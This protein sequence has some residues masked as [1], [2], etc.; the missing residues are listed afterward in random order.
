MPCSEWGTCGRLLPSNTIVWMYLFLS[1]APLPGILTFFRSSIR[2]L[3]LILT[4]VL[5]A[6]VASAQEPQ[7]TLTSPNPQNNGYFGESAAGLSDVDGDGL[8]DLLIGAPREDGGADQSGRVYA[9]SGATGELIHSLVSPSPVTNG[10]FGNDVAAVGDLDGDGREEWLIGAPEDESNVGKT[11]AAY[12]FSGDGESLILT[13]F[14]P[15]PE[16]GGRFGASVAAVPDVDGDGFDDLLVGAP[17]EDADSTDAGRAYLFSGATGSLLQTVTSQN[18]W[19]GGSFGESVSGVEDVDGDGSGDLLVGAYAEEPEGEEEG[20]RAYLFSGATGALL[21]AFVSP[22]LR[23]RSNFGRSVSSV[24]DIDG[25]G[26][27]DV[28]IGS[29]GDEGVSSALDPDATGAGRAYVFSGATGDLIYTLV[30]PKDQ[31]LGAFGAAVAGVQDASG[32]GIDD[33]LVG[34]TF[35]YAVNNGKGNAYLYSGADGMLLRRLVSATPQTSSEFGYT[36]AGVPDVD[37]DGHTDLLV[38]GYDLNQQPRWAGFAYLFSGARPVVSDPYGVAVP[39]SLTLTSP[40]AQINGAFGT[41]ISGVPDADGDGHDDILVGASS[42]NGGEMRSGQVHLLSGGRGDVLLSIP[43]PDPAANGHFGRAVAGVPDLDG[44]GRGDLLVAFRHEPKGAVFIG[45]VY[46]LSGAS[47]DLLYTLET[48]NTQDDTNRNDDLDGFGRAMAGIPD[49]D[50]DGHGDFIIGA[51][52]EWVDETNRGRAY[53]F[54]GATGELIHTL[55]GPVDTGFTGFGQSVAGV[56]DVDGDGRWDVLVSGLEPEFNLRAVYVYSGA[57]G[58]L[59][60]RLVSPVTDPTGTFGYAIS[61]VPDADGDGRGDVLIGA[62]REHSGADRSGRAYLF[63]G[64]TG[65]LIRTIDHPDPSIDANFGIAVSGISDTDGDGLGDLLVSATYRTDETAFGRVY[66]ISASSGDVVA[67][68]ASPKPNGYG[69]FGDAIAGFDNA[70]GSGSAIVAAPREGG[71]TEDGRVYV[72]KESSSVGIASDLNA[73]SLSLHAYPNPTQG[74]IALQLGT[75]HA[76]PV[77]IQLFDVLG[78]CLQE[79][80]YDYL[81]AG[82]HRIRF[83]VS[84]PVSGMYLIRATGSAGAVSSG[85]TVVR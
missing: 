26:R 23:F 21:Q 18:P 46:A 60:H 27:G 56:P 22:G 50:G 69:S 57:T 4:L 14:S 44:D 58:D 5:S 68:F 47:G 78:R 64:A 61:G 29:R 32:D 8:G 41:S 76:G 36:L 1:E 12:L 67:T 77:K 11:G 80:S 52:L 16:A 2:H 54:S 51:S 24:S 59:L 33:I 28:V 10:S 6:A 79:V 72:F 13:L 63:S 73:P 43:S 31:V 82:Q 84:S 45:R 30:S 15:D 35:E 85:V 55:N 83:D 34:A 7:R 40:D 71:A 66:L 38:G 39:P 25:D 74:P 75:P 17:G 48:P 9:V 42:E 37:G 81:A 53:V 65:S 20:G 49:V 3:A 62:Y 70:H 19:V